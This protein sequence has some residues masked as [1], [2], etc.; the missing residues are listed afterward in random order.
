MSAE[1][2]VAQGRKSVSLQREVVAG[3]TISHRDS[4]AAARRLAD[5]EAALALFIASRNQLEAELQGTR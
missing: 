2:H 5:L 4:A 3:T 1:W